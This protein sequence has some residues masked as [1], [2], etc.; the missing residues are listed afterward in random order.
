E[1]H[2]G[3]D[4]HSLMCW[5]LHGKAMSLHSPL[6]VFIRL[7]AGFEWTAIR[8]AVPVHVSK[9]AP[10]RDWAV[11]LNVGRPDFLPLAVYQLVAAFVLGH[12]LLLRPLLSNMRNERRSPMS[13]LWLAIRRN[14]RLW[15]EAP[16]P[17]GL[18]SLASTRDA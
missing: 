6:K 15:R 16:G 8:G 4:P 11:M 12:G 9:P 1:M 13:A 5:L 18:Q 17:L 10:A 14:R 3:S 2:T 7:L